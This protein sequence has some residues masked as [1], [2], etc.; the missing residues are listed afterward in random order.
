MYEGHSGVMFPI[1]W[2]APE[3]P[4]YNQFTIKSIVWSFGILL[5]ELI[6]YGGLPYPGMSNTQ[7]LEALKTGYRMPC[8][9]DCPEPLYEI[10]TECWRHDAASR[11]T[12]ETLQRRLEDF[13]L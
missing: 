6:T 12:F 13:F 4:M 2:T 3:A 7:V 8:P 11:P 10:M 5:Y 1:K 9:K